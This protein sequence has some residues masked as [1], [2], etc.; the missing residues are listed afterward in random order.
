MIRN[1]K[2]IEVLN[3]L[4]RINIDRVSGYEK[5]SHEEKNTDIGARNI[6]YKMA[7]ESR[8]YINELHAE[9]LHLG[10]A[11]VAKNT[12]SGRIYLFWLDLKAGFSGLDTQSL[13]VASEYGEQAI[14]KAYEWALSLGVDLPYKITSMIRD[15]QVALRRAL[16][17]V[18]R[19]RDSAII[20]FHHN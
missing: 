14:Q 4:I 6:F 11:P 7:M 17:L 9:V 10:G 3:D 1:E 13:L 5:A 19:Y 18:K 20:G 8:S 16:D 12:I 2:T 15:Q